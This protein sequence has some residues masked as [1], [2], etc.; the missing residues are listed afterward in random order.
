[1]EGTAGD[2]SFRDEGMSV[3]VAGFHAEEGNVKAAFQAE[4]AMS[5][6]AGRF[7][8]MVVKAA[9]SQV[10]EGMGVKV[11]KNI[12]GEPVVGAEAHRVKL[13]KDPSSQ[14]KNNHLGPC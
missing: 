10:E 3:M 12:L 8:S 6:K 7:P 1:M 2:E 4:E 13:M 11:E 5:V 9:N 14:W